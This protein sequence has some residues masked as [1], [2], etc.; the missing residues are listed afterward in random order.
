MKMFGLHWKRS[1][2]FE[3]VG[4]D[5][6]C[7]SFHISSAEELG[8]LTDGDITPSGLLRCSTSSAY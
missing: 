8:D 2:F 1:V 5:F 6:S 3:T 7:V 4:S